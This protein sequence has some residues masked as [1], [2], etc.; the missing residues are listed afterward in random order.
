MSVVACYLTKLIPE[1]DLFDW[2]QE[3]GKVH[4]IDAWK[5]GPV[6]RSEPMLLKTGTKW[7]DGNS[8]EGWHL[9]PSQERPT[10]WCS[11]VPIS[12]DIEDSDEIHCF[13]E[14][15]RHYFWRGAI[16]SP[17]TSC[18]PNQQCSVPAPS[19]PNSNA[20]ATKQESIH[21]LSPDI[22]PQLH[23]DSANCLHGLPRELN[24]TGPGKKSFW[25]QPVQFQLVGKILKYK[26][27]RHHRPYATLARTWT[28]DLI[29]KSGCRDLVYGLI[30]RD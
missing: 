29:S 11:P 2:C 13:V 16:F 18:R 23:N 10:T 5:V 24:F 22:L 17:P 6:N 14:V 3:L 19:I 28:I 15:Q 1:L 4:L 25:I 9:I 30:N 21:F 7:V 20:L 12:F 8:F 26:S 27:I